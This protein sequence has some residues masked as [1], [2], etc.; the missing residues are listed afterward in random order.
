[1]IN[2]PP[3]VIRHF[4]MK[5]KAVENAG[6]PA[7]VSDDVLKTTDFIFSRNFEVSRR[8]DSGQL[9][10]AKSKLNKAERYI[11][12]HEYTDCACNEFVY[13]KLANFLGVKV[14]AAKLFEITPD[15]KRKYFKTEFIVGIK[16]INAVAVQK[17]FSFTDKNLANNWQD[18]FKFKAL[19]DLFD[20]GDDIETILDDKGYIYRIDNTDAFRLGSYF[21]D[22]AGI[23]YAFEGFVDVKANIRKQILN[24]LNYDEGPGRFIYQYEK[25]CSKYGEN[26][27]KYYL[28][29]FCKMQ[30]VPDDY[31]NEF[32]NTLCHFYADMVGDYYRGY[33][34]KCKRIDFF[35]NWK[36][37]VEAV[38]MQ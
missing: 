16:Y 30:E 38:K 35:G 20:E 21:L 17:G 14:P 27:A 24:I 32:L 18:Y 13:S 9:M 12:K 29:P 36:T 31:I 15:E 5:N 6:K 7:L 37:R 34:E 2:T 4:R 23:D 26:Y 28:E 3:H 11:I 1:M 19:Y 8:G 25:L 33:I 10:L 22:L